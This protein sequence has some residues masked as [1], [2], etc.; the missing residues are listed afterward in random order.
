MRRTTSLSEITFDLNTNDETQ[1]SQQHGVGAA[2]GQHR[3]L[4][5]GG[6]D[7]LDQRF[8][9]TMISPTTLHRRNSADSVQTSHFLRCCSL[10]K[11]CLVP[12]HD[13][14]MYRGDS[15]FCSLECRQQ[16]MNKDEK[17]EKCSVLASKKETTSSASTARSQVSTKGESVAAL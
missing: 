4:P 2:S 9:A 15:A 10:C 11:R 16:Q 6:I 8:M 12:G 5:A 3:Q 14:Y 17:K 1:P 13:I 7:G